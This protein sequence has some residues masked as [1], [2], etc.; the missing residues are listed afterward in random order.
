MKKILVTG[1]TGQL[2]SELKVLS[3][4]YSQFEWIFADRSQ[5]SLDKLSVLKNQLEVIRPNIILNCGAYTAVDKAEME[6]ELA[7]IVNHEAVKVIAQY[8]NDNQV[9]LIHISTD[10]VFDGRSAIALTEE[11]VT[12][13]INVY[14]ATKRAGEVEAI[15]VNRDSIIIR[16]SWVYS[17]FGNNFVKTM[18]RLLQERESLG[19]VNDQIG[20]ATYAADLA[21]A[22]M[23]IVSAKEWIP[24]IYNYSNEGEISWYEFV[25]AIQVI[26]GDNCEVSGIPSSSYPTP[27][28]RPAFSLLDKAKIKRVYGISIPNYKE[29]LRK[30][31]GLAKSEI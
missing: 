22:M 15:A 11:A 27:A 26:T 12:E 3:K 4:N 10:Y 31:M 23:D 13:P 16:T 5:V 1:A 21:Q 30:C 19:V 17:S 8:A 18:K 9:K 24:G 6:P 7:D 20:S 2:G 29:S 14:G 28:K 25:L